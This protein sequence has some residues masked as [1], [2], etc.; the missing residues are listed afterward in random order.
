[1]QTIQ[2]TLTNGKVAAEF[3]LIGICRLD[4]QHVAS[5][6]RTTIF[7][8]QR[9]QKKTKKTTKPPP[10]T[11]SAHEPPISALRCCPSRG[12]TAVLGAVVFNLKQNFAE[13]GAERLSREG[14]RGSSKK[15]NT[16]AP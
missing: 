1:M 8:S 10:H 6:T 2:Q 4:I 13:L 14:V 15:G 7:M 3:V 5:S 16:N 11:H 12:Q 9:F